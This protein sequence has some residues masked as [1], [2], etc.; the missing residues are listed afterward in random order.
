MRQQL[1][2]SWGVLGFAFN[3]VRGI[4]DF[5][6]FI[7]V[8]KHFEEKEVLKNL[9]FSLESGKIYSLLGESGSGKTTAL[10]LINGL[11]QPSRGEVILNGKNIAHQDSVH[12]RR[13]MGYIIQGAGLFPHMNILEN[14][15]LVARR[16]GWKG[17]DCRKRALEL[18]NM[19]N[20]PAPLLESKPHQVSGGQRQRVGIIRALFLNPKIMLMDEPFGALDPLT[21]DDIQDE[22][23]SLQKDLKFSAIIVTHDL[24]EAFKMSSE[25][26]VLNQGNL[27]QK[28][29]PS[30]II[31]DPKTPYVKQLVDRFKKNMSVKYD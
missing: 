4:L 6:K 30:E 17:R 19:V 26:L 13:S 2:S 16:Q 8:E 12:L 11:T 29:K 9:N 28:A 3:E 23:L 24:H 10:R 21:R 15:T 18:M 1:F 22:F 20:L 14:I 25:V 5:L 31:G 7:S 27:D